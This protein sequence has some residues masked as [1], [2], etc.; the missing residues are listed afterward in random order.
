MTFQKRWNLMALHLAFVVSLKI[1]TPGW[2]RRQTNPANLEHSHNTVIFVDFSKMHADGIGTG[3][4][5]DNIFNCQ[6]HADG[7]TSYLPGPH[8][9]FNNV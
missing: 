5:A 8:Y 6:M 1:S 7:M 3:R 4:G 9:V 2:G